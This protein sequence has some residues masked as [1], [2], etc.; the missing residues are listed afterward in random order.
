[1]LP[2]R[3]WGILES[4]EGPGNGFRTYECT[5]VCVCVYVRATLCRRGVGKAMRDRTNKGSEW[6]GVSW[7]WLGKW[8]TRTPTC[9]S[10][11]HVRCHAHRLQIPVLDGCSL[12]G[13][14]S[15]WVC[16][17]VPNGWLEHVLVKIVGGGGF[18]GG[19]WGVLTDYTFRNGWMFG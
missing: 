2:G 13:C 1:M 6:G 4:G 17:L 19:S 16:L 15:A 7:L 18:W 5:Y 9:A 11:D 14:Q 8:G 10:R 12:G 3:G